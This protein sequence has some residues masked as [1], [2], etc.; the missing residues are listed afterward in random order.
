MCFF[1]QICKRYKLL[2]LQGLFSLLITPLYAQQSVG[3]GTNTPNPNAVLQLV[4]PGQNQGFLLPKLTT[5]QITSLG[6]TLVAADKGLQ[7]YDSLLQQIRYWDGSSWLTL[8]TSAASGT[9][10]S[11]GLSLPAI[12]NVS[13]SPVTTSGVLSATFQNQAQNTVF[14]GPTVGSASPTF[15]TLVAGDIPSLPATIITSGTL[16]IARGGTNGTA[17]PSSGAVAYGT[18]TAYA[19][20]SAGINGQLLQSTGAGAP[21]WINPPATLTASNGLTRTV[22]DIALGGTLSGATNINRAGFNLVVSGAGDFSVRPGGAGSERLF[23]NGTTGNVGIGTVTPLSPLQ[24]GTKLSIF[25]D[26]STS[27]EVIANNV[28]N[29]GTDF[30]YVTT[31]SSSALTLGSERVGLFTF[32]IGTAGNILA[33]TPSMRLNLTTLGLG[34]QVDNPQEILH[35]NGPALLNPITAPGTTTGRL[36]NVGGNLFWN[37]TNISAGSSGANLTLSNLTNPTAFNQDLRFDNSADRFIGFP[38]GFSPLQGRS[39]AISGEATSGAVLA[40]GNVSISG[41][42]SSTGVGGSAGITG[43]SSS[44]FAGGNV[45]I[46]AGDGGAQGGSTFIRGGNSSGGTGG[47]IFMTPGD[48]FSTNGNLYLAS[49]FGLGLVGRVGIGLNGTTESPTA[50]LD[51]TSNTS[52]RAALRLRNGV[53]PTTPNQGDIYADGNSVFYRNSTSWVDLG[54]SSSGW[55]LTG[56][57]GTTATD[58]IG[59][60]D[61]QDFRIRTNNLERMILAANGNIGI[62]ATVPR[63]RLQIG[64]RMGLVAASVDD[65]N[66]LTRNIYIDNADDP[67]YL[68]NGPA[69]VLFMDDNFIELAIH[70]TGVANAAVSSPTRNLVVGLNGIGLNTNNPIY[71]AHLVAGSIGYGFVHEGGGVRVGTYVNA[72]GGWLGTQSNHDLRLFTNDNTGNLIIQASTGNVGIGTTAPPEPLSVIGQIGWGTPNAGTNRLQSDQGGS[73]ELGGNNFTANPLVGAGPYIDFHFGNGIAE[74]FNFRLINSGNRILDFVDNTNVSMLRIN[75]GNIGLGVLAPVSRLDIAGDVHLADIVNPPA[76]T[77]NKLYNNGGNLFWNG[78]NIS[79]AGFSTLNSIPKGNG[80]GLVPSSIT[81]NGSEV[82]I[83][84]SSA[85]SDILRVVNTASSANVNI[86]GTAAGG[87]LIRL[88]AG[89][90]Q[91]FVWSGSGNLFMDANAGTLHLQTS[92][93]DRLFINNAGNIGIGT[94][95]PAAR[96]HLSGAIANN[97]QAHFTQGVTDGGF[98]LTASNGVA[99]GVGTKQADFGMFYSGSG[100]GS[101]FSFYRGVGALDGSIGINTNGAERMRIDNAGNV[102]IGNPFPSAPLHFANTVANRKIVLWEAANNEHQYFGFGINPN[103]LRF[104]LPATSERFGFFVSTSSTSSNEIMRIDGNGNVGIGTTVSPSYRLHVQRA[105]GA[106]IVADMYNSDG[107]Q[108]TQYNTN[109]APGWSPMISTGDHSIL[110]SNG[111]PE[112][113]A[114][115]IGQWSASGRGIRIDAIGRVGI[116]TGGPT[117]NL[118][119]Q[120][121][122][123]IDAADA[124]AGS[125]SNSIKFGSASGEAIGSRR[126]P[127]TNQFGIDFYTSSASRMSITNGG[128]VGIGTTNPLGRL[129]IANADYNLSPVHVSS[130]LGTAGATIRFTNPDFGARTYNLIGS[131]GSLSN[132]GAGYF[133]IYDDNAIAYRFTIGP[134][135]NTG[136]GVDV[137]QSRLHVQESISAGGQYVGR[138]INSFTGSA[139]GVALLAQTTNTSTNWGIGLE[140][141]GNYIGAY[142]WGSTGGFTALR[143]NANGATNAAYFDGNVQVIGALSK[144]SGTFKIDH[145]S[146]PSNKYLVHSFV[147]SPDMM[148]IYNG[149]ITTDANGEA[150]VQ[151]PDYF[152]VLNKD[153]RYQLT[154]IGT[155]AQ[156][157]VFEEIHEQANSFKVKTSEPQVKVSWQVTGVRKDPFANAN[158]VVDVVEKPAQEKGTY[159]HPELYGMPAHLRPGNKEKK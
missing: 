94:S 22:N 124:N 33:G 102:G 154:V 24:V 112:T 52:A 142:A 11:V 120:N 63:S 141:R 48:G 61:L 111:S 86:Q 67:F 148:N 119:V 147:E 1:D 121:G 138:F 23:V 109:A 8:S 71:P 146:D 143:A 16:P 85:G 77:T 75:N 152:N 46:S 64:S 78:T 66:A 128:N 74:D 151:L 69:N 59:T 134:A 37:G 13:G 155:F 135:G 30:R 41:G 158:R 101:S 89:L 130:S 129:H 97:L 50:L 87:S 115:F 103:T 105:A 136:I 82:A 4:S 2:V 31:N 29:D 118:T 21:I 150:V 149:N 110:Y 159:L 153:F 122:M 51:I 127:G 156:A 55:S 58:F 157:I 116:G 62:G 104:Q 98:K 43:G 17:A 88:S 139:D 80:L 96:F 49:E 28:Y 65:F 40:G 25:T 15:R 26:P 113:G 108:W 144:S 73:I 10:S 56:N 133:G 39:L 7:V 18:G 90:Q 137:A 76:P 83:T 38:A 84:S 91:T 53:P 12:F 32:P 117:E 99:G 125:I 79:G 100:Y 132:M 70:P 6:L 36:Y 145:P 72:A 3:I 57:A 92:G 5:G 42:F 114:L 35:I 9:V 126:T 81:D 140:A 131:T 20:T 14:A 54:G 93:T 68:N 95:S 44:T 107:S 60:T 106:S 27:Q 47:N 123:N 19:F 34:I 45:G